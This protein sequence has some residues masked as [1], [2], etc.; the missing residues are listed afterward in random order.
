MDIDHEV[1]SV[2]DAPLTPMGHPFDIGGV[3][4]D[5][6]LDRDEEGEDIFFK[7]FGTRLHPQFGSSFVDLD[8]RTA[9]VC[10]GQNTRHV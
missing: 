6:E 10:G 4:D 2:T 1:E 7:E 3:G 9:V 8:S 5:H